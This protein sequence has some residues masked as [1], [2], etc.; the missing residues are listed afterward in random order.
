MSYEKLQ[1]P[2]S[3]E[4]ELIR[5]GITRRNQPEQE[6]VVTLPINAEEQVSEIEAAIKQAF[7][8]FNVDDNPDLRSAILAQISQEWMQQQEEHEN[9]NMERL[10]VAT[11]SE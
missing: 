2:E 6:W 1:H 8:E 7:D 9:K 4:G 3:S 11:D 10:K 5:V